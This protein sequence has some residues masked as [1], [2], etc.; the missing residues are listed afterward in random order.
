MEGSLSSLEMNYQIDHVNRYVSNVDKF[1][2]FYQSALGFKLIGKGVKQNGRR[3]AILQGSGHELFISEKDGF[4][5]GCENLRHIGYS[6]DNADKILIELKRKGYADEEQKVVVKQYSRQVYIK[7][8][9]GM[10]IDLIQWTD[11]AGF[12]KSLIR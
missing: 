2:E 4:E 5:A 9:D 8:P 6:V 1:I 10:E 7:D 3:Y 12:Y 11:K